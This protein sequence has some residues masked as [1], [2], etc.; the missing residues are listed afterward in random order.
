[1]VN[2]LPDPTGRDARSAMALA[3]SLV[4]QGSDAS[5]S[6][7]Q[8]GVARTVRI[9]EITA[10]GARKPI[11]LPAPLA[12]L[13]GSEASATEPTSDEVLLLTALAPRT[14]PEMAGTRAPGTLFTR[15]SVPGAS[16]VGLVPLT[17]D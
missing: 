8:R 7:R 10:P 5:S 16:A 9:I 14:R 3:E 11:A 17:G 15:S 2:V 6:L 12:N 1:M 13:I 4:K